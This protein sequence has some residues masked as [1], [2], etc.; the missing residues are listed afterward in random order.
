MQNPK[1]S[2]VFQSI[3]VRFLVF[4]SLF[5]SYYICLIYSILFYYILILS[6]YF[7]DFIEGVPV[8]LHAVLGPFWS[9]IPYPQE[10]S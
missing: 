3:L 7:L 6:Y 5:L 8:H 2:K 10:I 1:I 9:T 4:L